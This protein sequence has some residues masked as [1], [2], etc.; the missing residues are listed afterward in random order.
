MAEC[1]RSLAALICAKTGKL[2]N[3]LATLSHINLLICDRTNV[4]S[5]MPKE[6]FFRLYYVAEL[7]AAVAAAPFREVLFVAKMR[8]ATGFV[9]LKTLLLMAEVYFFNAIYTAMESRGIFAPPRAE[10]EVFGSYFAGRV[11][12]P[13]LFR[14]AADGTE[15]IYGDSGFF[16]AQDRSIFVRTYQD[17][18]FPDDARAPDASLAGRLGSDFMGRLAELHASNTFVTPLLFP[19]KSA[20]P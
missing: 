5:T 9:P 16:V 14:E 1:A 3:S 4:L 17:G 20:H 12:G 8:D 7:R 2:E 15:V 13:V 6:E 18:F 10:L 11:K 19:T